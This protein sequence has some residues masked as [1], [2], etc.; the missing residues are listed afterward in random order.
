MG[1]AGIIGIWLGIVFIAIG[2]AVGFGAMYID[3]DSI[4]VNALGLVP[5][6]FL[7]LLVGTVASQMSH[8]HRHYNSDIDGHN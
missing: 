5:L 2:L 6:G 3:S 4:A 7:L 8:P 1:R